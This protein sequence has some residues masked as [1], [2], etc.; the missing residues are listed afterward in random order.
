MILF[1]RSA[2]FHH[3][4]IVFDVPY[5]HALNIQNL[6]NISDTICLAVSAHHSAKLPIDNV[7]SSIAS[8]IT[9]SK[10]ARAALPIGVDSNA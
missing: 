3:S 6:L 7:Q 9:P 1:I 2:R 10:N 8:F 4:A 5:A